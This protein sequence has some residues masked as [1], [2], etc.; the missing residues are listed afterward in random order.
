MTCHRA[1]RWVTKERF[2]EE[3]GE[4]RGKT[5]WKS[6][7]VGLELMGKA[8][9]AFMMTQSH[10]LH[11]HAF[12]VDEVSMMDLSLL[13]S[14][15]AAIPPHASVV[16]I[17]DPDQLPSV[18]VGNALRDLISSAVI[19]VLRLTE[20]L[21]QLTAS[22]LHHNVRA[23]NEGRM[24]QLTDASVTSPPPQSDSL[25]MREGGVDP[26]QT[27]TW[28]TRVLMPA[29]QLN[30]QRDLQVLAPIK[31]GPVGT[32]ALN[33]HMQALL[34]PPS[35][36]SPSLTYNGVVYRVGDRVMQGWNDYEAEVFNGDIGRVQRVDV[37][38]GLVTVQYPHTV[39]GYKG[40]ELEAIGLAWAMTVHKSQGSEYPC[41][42]L[43]CSKQHQFML[44][45]SLLYTAVSRARRVLVVVGGREA[46][47]R[48]V[49]K[50]EERLRRSAL[51][52]RLRR[53]MG[54]SVDADPA[55]GGAAPQVKEHT[56]ALNT[57]APSKKRQG[58][59]VYK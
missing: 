51:R 13:T 22:T 17:G 42:V 29:V 36:S 23:V 7:K 24:P 30:A 43:I 49:W 27:L 44:Y 38:E 48:G 11:Q 31:R 57:S 58:V 34:N 41:V 39:V 35:P 50:R 9:G 47:A 25:F 19:P 32:H 33:A 14:M 2:L 10:P 54:K 40:V 15:L 55:L 4:G 18:G 59:S 45:R 5:E 21:R 52:L 12:V 37:A 3:W 16:L 53:A 20:P 26:L 56:T 8:T 6:H 28:I 1:L 46:L